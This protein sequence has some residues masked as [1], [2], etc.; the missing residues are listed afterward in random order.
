MDGWYFFKTRQKRDYLPL[1]R[2]EHGFRFKLSWFYAI[3]VLWTFII[4]IEIPS[5]KHTLLLVEDDRLVMETLSKGL[6]E[7]GYSVNIAETVDEAED[8]LQCND[9]PD[10][11]IFDISM[12]KKE[13]LQLVDRLR[14]FNHIPFIILSAFID[15]DFIAKANDFGA[16]N[17]LHKPIDIADLA[18]SIE[19]ALANIRNLRQQRNT[20]Q[21]LQQA[22]DNE[23]DIR[24]A[25]GIIM[26][27][28]R[29]TRMEA[30]E[31]L[32]S[33]ARSRR[34]KLSELAADIIQA[35]ETLN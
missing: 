21:Q 14:L 29:L 27:Q 31:L 15:A 10:L 35:S 32:R 5:L 7:R 8:S 13:G 17:Y 6:I 30:F 34:S 4:M 12:S 22:L 23:R 28:H 33:T 9:R 1:N 25:I 26:V 11:V 3:A 20:E 24:T 2:N 18:L 16:L 19:A